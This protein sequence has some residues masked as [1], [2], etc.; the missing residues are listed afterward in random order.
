[1]YL[2]YPYLFHFWV[3]EHLIQ[4]R[5]PPLPVPE[6][7]P[8][9]SGPFTIPALTFHNYFISLIFPMAG[10]A[11]GGPHSSP[12]SIRQSLTPSAL[13]SPP[14]LIFVGSLTVS[15]LLS[16]MHTQT[17]Y[18]RTHNIWEI[19]FGEKQWQVAVFHT[20]KRNKS[21]EKKERLWGRIEDHKTVNKGEGKKK[22]LNIS[23]AKQWKKV[24]GKK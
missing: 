6:P 14:I 5:Q 3:T 9:L 11:P 21:W 17:H 20:S 16:L 13:L 7:Q 12:S 10:S 19:P 1:M 8:G 18:A 23:V 2:L 22:T 4:L 24:K 15:P